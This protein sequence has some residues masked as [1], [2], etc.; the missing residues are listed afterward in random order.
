MGIRVLEIDTSIIVG[1]MPAFASLCKHVSTN[2]TLSGLVHTLAYGPWT[3]LTTRTRDSRA[4]DSN[5]THDRSGNKKRDY[6][7][8]M[9]GGRPGLPAVNRA[10]IEH[11][12]KRPTDVSLLMNDASIMKSINM[13]VSYDDEAEAAG[14]QHS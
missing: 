14:T 11:A 13:E 8:L 9:D 10:R 6:V 2:K 4:Q 1:C 5:D 12:K 3:R 7:E